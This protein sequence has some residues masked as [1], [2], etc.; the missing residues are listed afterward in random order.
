MK[1]YRERGFLSRVGHVGAY[2]AAGV[3]LGSA[4]VGAN[5][6]H[7]L[8]RNGQR[9][10]PSVY[11]IIIVSSGVLRALY[12]ASDTTASLRGRF[13]NTKN[14]SNRTSRSQVLPAGSVKL[15]YRQRVDPG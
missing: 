4:E 1:I 3:T 2:S 9:G 12:V 11:C 13:L 7:V 6:F 10:G 8:M 14:S 5:W 15:V